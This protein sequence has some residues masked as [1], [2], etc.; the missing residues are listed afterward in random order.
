MVTDTLPVSRSLPPGLVQA[1]KAAA[2]V[3]KDVGLCSDTPSAHPP[4]TLLHAGRWAPSSILCVSVVT[5]SIRSF[6]EEKLLLGFPEPEAA[7][8]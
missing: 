6:R 2:L 7:A 3:G 1:L 8:S 4:S 5:E